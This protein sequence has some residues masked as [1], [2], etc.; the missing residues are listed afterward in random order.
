MTANNPLKRPVTNR[1]INTVDLFE[2]LIRTIA[3]KVLWGN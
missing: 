2:V 1:F 3:R